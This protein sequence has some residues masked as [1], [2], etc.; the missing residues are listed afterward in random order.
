MWR[1]GVVHNPAPMDGTSIRP[2]RRTLTSFLAAL[3]ILALTSLAL[4]ARAGA[5]L[6]WTHGCSGGARVAKAHSDGSD[7]KPDFIHTRH[8]CFGS[9]GVAVHGDHV[10]WT[11]VE[12]GA[13]GRANLDGTRSNSDFIATGGGK[14]TSVAV[15][16][17]HIYWTNRAGGTIGRANLS[18]TQ[19]DPFFIV[20]PYNAATRTSPY[21][22]PGPYGV[23]ADGENIYWTN[24][25]P[26][27]EGVIGRA[28]LNGRMVNQRFITGLTL[29]AGIAVGSDHIYWANSNAVPTS[30]TPAPGSIGLANIDGTGVNPTFIPLTSTPV[31][32]ALGVGHVYWTN[33][34]GSPAIGRA[35]KDGTGITTGL[36]TTTGP[37]G[38]I[39]VRA[40][41]Y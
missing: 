14:P 28:S 9:L 41:G 12:P 15:D 18:G 35:N 25:T 13:I 27:G 39:A 24:T 5:V 7:V 34:G 32:V 36:V 33:F 26:S 2:K 40:G 17:D 38:G 1:R 21:V 16:R 6:L 3:A 30:T 22:L 37:A 4:S 31:G 29:P 20:T 8:G 10:Y 23:A 19:V 11:S